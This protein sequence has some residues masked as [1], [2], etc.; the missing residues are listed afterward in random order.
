MPPHHKKR[1]VFTNQTNEARPN[2]K[3]KL[4]SHLTLECKLFD[5]DESTAAVLTNEGSVH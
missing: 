4:Y 5:A 2:L 3:T 1:Q